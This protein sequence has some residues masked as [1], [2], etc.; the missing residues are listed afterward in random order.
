LPTNVI[1]LWCH[2]IQYN[3]TQHSAK[4]AT[5]SIKLLDGELCY[6]KCHYAECRKEDHYA[7]FR[8]AGVIM[9]CAVI[10]SVA[11]FSVGAPLQERQR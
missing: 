2:D 11:W 10:L 6:A 3:D 8:Y 5:L 1:N 7:E 4:N 9:Q